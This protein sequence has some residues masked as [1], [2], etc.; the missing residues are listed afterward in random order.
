MKN[1]KEKFNNEIVI[2][3]GAVAQAEKR[4]K[5]APQG[6]LRI[7]GNNGKMQYYY[8]NSESDNGYGHYLKKSEHKLA[9]AIA[10]RDYDEKLA[11]LATER[12]RLLEYFMKKEEQTSLKRLYENTNEYRRNLIDVPVLSDEEYVKRWQAVEYEGKAFSE[13]AAEIYSN[14]GERV[15]SKSEKIIADKLYS[16]GIPYRYEYPVVLKGNV[17]MH[18]DF[19]ILKMPER[20][21]VYLEHLGMMDDCGYV[22]KVM[23]KLNTYER[24]DIYL[25]VNLFVTYETGKNPLNT[26]SLEGLLKGAFQ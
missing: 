4:L 13:D 12:I 22:E 10:Q 2:L 25:G 15:R 18:P 8:R 21:E 20:E 9:K 1:L 19:T 5:A 23:L 26:R 7:K 11:K 6:R 16:M 14:R 3:K 24:N 17:K